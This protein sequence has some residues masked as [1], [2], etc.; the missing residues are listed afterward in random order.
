ML[1]YSA[2]A[3]WSH[4][5][6]LVGMFV[7]VF[8]GVAFLSGTMVLSDT[9]RAGIGN[10]FATAYDGTDAVVRSVSTVSDTPGAIRSGIPSSLVDQVGTVPGVAQAAP[11]ISGYGQIVAADGTQL[12][13]NGPRQA[14]NWIDGS[15]LNPYK[16]AE[17]RAPSADTEVVIDRGSAKSGKLHVGDQTTILTPQPVKVTI[18]GI[19]TFGTQ[20]SYGQTS[21]TGFTLAG[22]DKY[23][24]KQPGTVSSISIRATAGTSQTQVQQAI[25]AV[26]PAGVE[27]ITGKQLTDQLL[28]D[29]DKSFLSLF[30]TFLTVFAAIALLVAMF[31]IHNTFSILAAQRARE[32]ALLRAVG[33]TRRQVLW[34]TVVEAFLI[35]VIASAV[36][37]LGGLGIATLL[38]GAFSGFGVS[39]P[40]DTVVLNGTTIAVAL[41]VGIVVTVLAG[42]LPAVSSSRIPPVAA[43]RDTAIDRSGGSRTRAVIGVIAVLLGVAAALGGLAGG[44]STLGLVAL[45]AVVL[46]VGVIVLGPTAARPASRV[47]GAP[48]ARLRG[49][50]GALAQQNAGRNPRRTAGAAAALLIGVTVVSLITVFAASFQSSLNQSLSQDF[51]GDLVVNSGGFGNQTGFGQGL[52][53]TLEQLP[54]VSGAAGTGLEDVLVGTSATK[55]QVTIADPIAVASVFSLDQKS[56]DVAKLGDG[57]LAVSEPLATDK[58]WKVGSTVPIGFPDGSKHDLAVGAIYGKNQL[59]GDYLVPV[60]L[61]SAHSPTTLFSVVYVKLAQGVSLADGKKAV[62]QATKSFGAPKVQD[63]DEFVSLAV[64]G[65]GQF[66]GLVYVLLALAVIIAL[67][68]ITNTLSLAVYERTRELG[69]LRAVGATRRQVR[70]MVRGESVITALFGT[71]GGIVL[72]VF[73]GWAL[74]EAARSTVTAFRLPVTQLIIVLVIG[75]IAGLLAGWRPASRAARLNLLAAIASE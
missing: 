75:G 54:E 24:N 45:G 4:K 63:R 11:V 1:S 40:G 30:Q 42:V 21:F 73:L 32:S 47:L 60:G 44:S 16:I 50:T 35:G 72:G 17:G 7:A 51:A 36:G 12:T 61:S 69:L 52:A 58:G 56:G 33:A 22:A 3:L 2:R 43:I 70:S 14:G 57:Q 6:R 66:L 19:A 65:I 23:I 38:K 8:L 49:V 27:V 71:V 64:N 9:L 18:V 29:V 41:P 53:T 67:L 5:R 46:L 34:M 20:D 10:F 15:G 48:L 62:Q 26:L 68:G 55:T 31:T 74:V 39:L 37:L 25:K 28:G 59:L 13:G